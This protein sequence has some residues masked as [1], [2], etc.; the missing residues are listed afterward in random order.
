MN[1][2]DRTHASDKRT[3]WLQVAELTELRLRKHVLACAVDTRPLVALLM[4]M[5]LSQQQDQDVEHRFEASK[6]CSLR[7]SLRDLIPL[8]RQLRFLH[9]VV[10][11]DAVAD[12]VV[13][14]ALLVASAC[15]SSSSS[16]LLILMLNV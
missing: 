15:L 8:P 11:V 2:A 16:R 6:A 3:R 12:V 13:V 7:R 9:R 5:S 10:D 14:V 4:P 1:L